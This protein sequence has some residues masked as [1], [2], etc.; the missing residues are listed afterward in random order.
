MV[1]TTS[2]TGAPRRCFGVD[3]TRVTTAVDALMRTA[4]VE[5]VA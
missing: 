1:S 2:R 5:A 4:S 3:A